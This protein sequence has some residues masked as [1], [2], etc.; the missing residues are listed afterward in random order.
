MGACAESGLAGAG[1][2]NGSGS[3]RNSKS[4]GSI[5]LASVRLLLSGEVVRDAAV[6]ELGASC[7]A[8]N[9]CECQ[10]PRLENG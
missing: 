6:L 4:S 2:S 8:F 7:K 5:S 9:E 1:F 10:H 3:L